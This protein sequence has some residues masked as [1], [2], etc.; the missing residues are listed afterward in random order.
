MGGATRERSGANRMVD[1]KEEEEGDEE[2][3]GTNFQ[4]GA[5][6]KWEFG[7]SGPRQQK[8]EGK[9][10]RV[11]RAKKRT[12]REAHAEANHSAGRVSRALREW[13]QRRNFHGP[14]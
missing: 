4:I 11:E 3:G 7:E 12:D 14:G 2:G 13:V 9:K 8:R 10:G 5:N 6:S 1:D